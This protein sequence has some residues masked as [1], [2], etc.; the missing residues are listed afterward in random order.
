MRTAPRRPRS[1]Q[2][3]TKRASK[4]RASAR[5][6]ARREV[7]EVDDQRIRAAREHRVV[8]GGVGAGSE[9]PGA[10]QV[11]VEG[12]HGFAF[13]TSGGRACA[14]VASSCCYIAPRKS[15]RTD[16]DYY[17]EER[18]EMKI[19]SHGALFW[20]AALLL[21]AGCASTSTAP[22][23]AWRDPNFTGKPFSK[24]FVIGLSSKDLTDRRGF[25]DLMVA[26]LRS[27]GTQA[28]PACNSCRARARPT[29]RA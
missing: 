11:G 25:E 17:K 23:S 1:R 12:G 5:R 28:V 10:T 2:P 26:A 3:W 6:G 15:A 7:F 16:V 20:V 24:V 21:I 9:E 29:R 22:S 8:R 14:P 27:G 13:C 18:R 4:S 19:R